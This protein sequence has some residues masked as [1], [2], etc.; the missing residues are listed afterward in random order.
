M[1]QVR[2]GEGNGHK[3]T[4]QCTKWLGTFCRVRLPG[5]KQKQKRNKQPSGSEPKAVDG[6]S[7]SRDGT[8]HRKG[9]ADSRHTTFR[10]KSAHCPKGTRHSCS[11][12]AGQ[13]ALTYTSVH[14]RR[15]ILGRFRRERVGFCRSAVVALTAGQASPVEPLRCNHNQR[16]GRR[17]GGGGFGSSAQSQSGSNQIGYGQP[18]LRATI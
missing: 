4:P 9:H 15:G 13:M 7:V 1:T 16:D 11:V 8:H 14:P 2:S 10:I 5:S 12:G 6:P 18:S 3:C 17:G